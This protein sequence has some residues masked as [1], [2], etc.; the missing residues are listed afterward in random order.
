MTVRNK[1]LNS[2]IEYFKNEKIPMN[3]KNFYLVMISNGVIFLTLLFLFIFTK[4]TQ[5]IIL[6][7]VFLIIFIV[8]LSALA[9]ISHE[10]KLYSF[11]Y[12]LLFNFFI[13]PLF[14]FTMGDIYN[15]TIFFFIL[16][17]IITA[18]LNSN[19]RLLTILLV[20]EF[21]IYSA[22]LAFIYFNKEAFVQTRTQVH[23]AHAIIA[24]FTLAA[25]T[26]SFLCV[27]Q[28]YIY[29]VAR[30]KMNDANRDIYIAQSSRSR[31]LANMTHE[32]RTPM[33]AI[34]GM[35]N[36][37]LK[38]DLNDETKDQINIVKDSASQLLRI[39][40]DILEFSKLDSGKVSLFNTEYSFKAL[41]SEIIEAVSAEYFNDNVDL[42][43][44]VSR[45]TPDA[46]FGD[47]I[48]IRQIFR[49]ILFSSLSQTS[50]GTTYINIESDVDYDEKIAD[51]KCRIASTGSGFSSA[52]LNSMFNAYSNYD[53]RQK[54]SFK[55]MGLELNICKSMLNL[56]DGD[57]SVDS[58]EGIG[59]AVTFN[60]RNYIIEESCVATEYEKTVKP[61]VYLPDKTKEV[62]WQALMRDLEISATY[63]RNISS[64]KMC[65]ENSKYTQIYVRDTYFDDIKDIIKSFECEDI[66]YVVCEY[67]GKYGDF[68]DLKILRLPLYSINFIESLNG[69]WNADNYR[70]QETKEVVTYPEAK[71]LI[72]DDSVI[73][74]KVEESLLANYSIKPRLATSGR[75]ALSILKREVFDLVILDQKMP[76]F[77]GIDTI[78]EIRSSEFW[79]NDI[80]C[81]C[82][83]AEFGADTK[84]KLT[85]E[86]FN[87]YLAKPINLRYLDKMLKEY[88]PEELKVVSKDDK[89]NSALN[90]S[91]ALA[92]AEEPKEDLYLFDPAIGVKNLGDNEEAYLSVLQAYYQ[93]G[94]NKFIEVPEMLKALDI[95]LYTTN[96]HALK[97]SSATVGAMGI[98]P[99]FKELEFAGKANDIDF[100]NNNSKRTFEAFEVVLEKV[101]E[102]LISKNAF[103]ES[104]DEEEL[105]EG[106]AITLELDVLNELSTCIT[107]MNLRRAEE[108]IN[109]LSSNN[110]GHSI[111][112]QIKKIK[113]S[114]DN[115]EYMDIVEVINELTM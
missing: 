9:K 113:D 44:S 13:T 58:I 22:I 47:D 74:L 52:E 14:F 60:F 72:V 83:T 105:D 80:P 104:D 20:L 76:E 27:Y 49:Y 38:E 42:H 93:E 77:D 56:M 10:E 91:E 114:Y 12:C 88:L 103:E 99:K 95:S 36:L 71:V 8:C 75:E 65:L 86:G 4:K 19:S 85:N 46:L 1:Y 64:F 23:T 106:D 92:K 28:T 79:Q 39:I 69:T 82:A 18:F 59:T 78:H 45:N 6:L 55:G 97:S 70:Q 3:E 66:T 32:I 5:P 89:D 31:F 110:Y 101:K 81:I 7:A 2:I 98:S 87:D 34:I 53:S 33:N 107:T 16:G 11:I 73:N 68:G 24:C 90:N 35:T 25:F 63:A 109:E 62:F 15:G 108:I 100:I 94:L 48:K 67:N 29:K 50:Y 61:I 26:V 54:S 102:Y 111:N 96:V 112:S 17:F 30:E 51:I 41:I 40:N 37:I 57:L 115:F 43:V 84:D 21:T